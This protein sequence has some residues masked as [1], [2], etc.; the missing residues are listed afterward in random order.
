MSI[1]TLK[2]RTAPGSQTIFRSEVLKDVR[3]LHRLAELNL[4]PGFLRG[5]TT[6]NLPTLVK[7]SLYKT[8]N[9]V[10]IGAR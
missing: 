2:N 9:A 1:L 8:G 4:H 6:A 7:F 5:R 3:R 10:V